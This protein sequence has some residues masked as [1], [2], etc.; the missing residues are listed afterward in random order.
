MTPQSESPVTENLPTDP[1]QRPDWEQL[2]IAYLEE[3]LAAMGSGSPPISFRILAERYGVNY[4]SLRNVAGEQRWRDDLTRLSDEQ[5]MKTNTTIVNLQLQNEVEV[6]VRQAQYAR[7]AQDKAMQK[8]QVLQPAQMT[9][10]DAI[11]LLRLGLE[12]ERKALG[13][14]DSFTPPPP[15][16][17]ASGQT[18]DAVRLALQSISNLKRRLTLEDPR[19]LPDT[20]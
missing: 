14:E 5:R 18:R 20:G 19:D 4:G 1:R 17:M 2:R 16:H 11:D 3:S 7:L 13:M 8:L 9:T 6:R 15:S 12:Q 10:R